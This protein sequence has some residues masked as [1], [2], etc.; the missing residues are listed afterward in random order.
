MG[1]PVVHFEF[2]SKD[3]ERISKF[4]SEMFGWNINA[5][6]GMDYRFVE[7]KN[8]RGIG[9]GIMKPQEGGPWPG[10][11]A[12]YVE[13]DDID[14]KLSQIEAAGGKVLVPKQQ[15]PGMGWFA[16]FEDP[17]ARVNGLWEMNK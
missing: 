14:A 8:E 10:N 12:L 15:I 17:D 7:T 3:P 2:W 1:S 11:M 5:M 4:Y 9:G 16:L 6:P 13:V